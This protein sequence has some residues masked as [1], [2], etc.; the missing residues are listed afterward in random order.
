MESG[1]KPC[2]FQTVPLCLIQT[3]PFNSASIK[4]L[5]NYLLSLSGSH[6]CFMLSIKYCLT[7]MRDAPQRRF[8]CPPVSDV[9]A[10]PVFRLFPSRRRLWCD[11]INCGALARPRLGTKRSFSGAFFLGVWTRSAGRLS[12]TSAGPRIRGGRDVGSACTGGVAAASVLL[13]LCDVSLSRIS[14]GGDVLDWRSDTHE[15]WETVS[16]AGKRRLSHP[17][18]PSPLS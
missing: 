13:S 18:H 17:L 11:V 5:H 3:V 7:G 12:L 10:I 6:P 14:F 2:W 9:F 16:H 4:K 15:A 8:C 1:A